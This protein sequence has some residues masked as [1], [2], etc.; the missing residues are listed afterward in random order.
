MFPKD[1]IAGEKPVEIID[2][3]SEAESPEQVNLQEM[4]AIQAMS[5]CLQELNHKYEAMGTAICDKLDALEG[6]ARDLEARMEAMQ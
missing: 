2:E 3:I 6:N 5:N 4:R 1:I